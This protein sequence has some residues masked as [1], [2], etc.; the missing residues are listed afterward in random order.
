MFKAQN[1]SRVSLTRY[2][3]LCFEMWKGFVGFNISYLFYVQLYMFFLS[4]T[5]YLVKFYNA[6][7]EQNIFLKLK[8]LKY[9]FMYVCL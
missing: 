3:I 2:R 7:E 4:L 1:H 9:G 8:Y 6:K 5:I